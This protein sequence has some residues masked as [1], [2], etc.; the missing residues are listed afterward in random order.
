MQKRTKVALGAVCLVAILY[1]AWL[2]TPDSWP[3]LRSGMRDAGVIAGIFAGSISLFSLPAGYSN[4]E[5]Q[6]TPTPKL[7]WIYFLLLPAIPWGLA[8]GVW[9]LYWI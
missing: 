5:R 3:I 4:A 6:S 8:C 1:L 9:L 2:L 7:W